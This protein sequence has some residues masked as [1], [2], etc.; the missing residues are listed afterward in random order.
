MATSY[1]TSWGEPRTRWE[2]Q[3]FSSLVDRKRERKSPRCPRAVR[4]RRIL[5][6]HA[7]DKNE[8]GGGIAR[9]GGE[10][11]CDVVNVPLRAMS[12]RSFSTFAA[13]EKRRFC[14]RTGWTRRSGRV[15][16]FAR[17]ACVGGGPRRRDGGCRR[18]GASGC[19]RLVLDW[20]RCD[21][22]GVR[23]GGWF[24]G[25]GLRRARTQLS[26][27]S[28]HALWGG[29]GEGVRLF[30]PLPTSSASRPRGDTRTGACFPSGTGNARRRR[31]AVVLGEET[32]KKK[33]PCP[34]CHAAP[35]LD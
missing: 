12:R 2:N 23:G 14:H 6:R 30:D 22:M 15:R 9:R 19:A 5:A 34:P 7:R 33:Y 27:F 18:G 26:R 8:A 28:K 32:G 35:T 24:V 31:L 16:C 13:A 29:G 10:G 4:R 1:G 25:D 21:R 11:R 17:R 3:I 20:R